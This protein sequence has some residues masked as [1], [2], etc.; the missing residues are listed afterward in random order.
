MQQLVQHRKLVN[1][2]IGAFTIWMY[3]DH[4]TTHFSALEHPDLQTIDRASASD[5][6]VIFLVISLKTNTR[7]CIDGIDFFLY[8]EC[9][10]QCG[11]VMITA[12]VIM[13]AMYKA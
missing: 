10:V 7:Y 3:C 2:A 6:H 8:Q 9:C 12:F 5:Q 11:K 1:A 13:I 4:G